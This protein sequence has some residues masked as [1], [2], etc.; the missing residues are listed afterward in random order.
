MAS[1]TV[2]RPSDTLT[3]STSATGYLVTD[4]GVLDLAGDSVTVTAHA[5]GPVVIALGTTGD[6]DAWVGESRATHVTG[7]TSRTRARDGRRQGHHDAVAD[8]LCRDGDHVR[9][10]DR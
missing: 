2:W 8:H 10:A 3:A 7:L 1:A 9:C 5:A 6:V 4:P